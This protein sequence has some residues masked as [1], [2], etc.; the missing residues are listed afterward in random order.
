MIPNPRQMLEDF[1]GVTPEIF[2][3]HH[4][5][6]KGHNGHFSTISHMFCNC[7]LIEGSVMKVMEVWVVFN[8]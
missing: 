6:Q 7:L 8:P 3:L 4:K 2:C 5:K 1:S